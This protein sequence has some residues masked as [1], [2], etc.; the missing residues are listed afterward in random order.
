MNCDLLHMD[1]VNGCVFMGAFVDFKVVCMVQKSEIFIEINGS[2]KS[3]KIVQSNGSCD[4]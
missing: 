3:S 1:A 2:R 4:C